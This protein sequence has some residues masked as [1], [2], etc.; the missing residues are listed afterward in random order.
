MHIR[1]ALI[2]LMFITACADN[3]GK[4]IQV[5]NVTV[6]YTDNVSKDLANEF[7]DYWVAHEFNGQRPQYM[8][9]SKL[10][11][12][13]RLK[14]IAS[15]STFLTDIPFETQL[16]LVELESELK[17]NVFQQYAFRIVL[18]DNQFNKYNS[19]TD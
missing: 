19:I 15:D 11:N 16:M 13:I 18:S 8:Q 7:I 2:L 6:Y 4:H 14:L 5:G 10:D 12:E 1:L 3:Y 17:K 9:L